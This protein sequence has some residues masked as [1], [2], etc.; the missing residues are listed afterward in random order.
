MDILSFILLIAAFS[1]SYTFTGRYFMHM[2]QLNNYNTPV[3]LKWIEKRAASVLVKAVLVLSTIPLIIFFKST[4]ML[5]SGIIYIVLTYYYKPKDTRQKMVYTK[6]VI[7]MLVTMFILSLIV[8]IL[9]I[10][11]YYSS[12]PLLATIL[13]AEFV[14]SPI[15][16][17]VVKFIN[18][19]MEKQI[20][21]SFVKSAN[22][23][24]TENIKLK[25]IVVGGSFGKTST[26]RYLSELLNI[27]YKVYTVGENARNNI[28]IIKELSTVE[29]DTDIFLCE[30]SSHKIGETAELCK[31]LKPDI[32]I[33]TNIGEQNLDTFKSIEN[34]AQSNKELAQFLENGKLYVNADMRKLVSMCSNFEPVTYGMDESAQYKIFN[35][36]VGEGGTGFDIITPDGETASFVTVLLGEHN[37][38]NL[39]AAIITAHGLGISFED[40]KTVVKNIKSVPHR[41]EL[42]TTANSI[43]IDDSS[44]SNSEGAE[45][46]LNIL[47]SFPDCTKILITPGMSNYA[48][49]QDEYNYRLGESACGICDYVVLIG[50]KQTKYVLAALIENDFDLDKIFVV[51]SLPNAF[52]TLEEIAGS[53]GKKAILLENDIPQSV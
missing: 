7:R 4:G 37:I 14:M 22:E 12:I 42:V 24:I 2:F 53:S 1:L 8:F 15:T 10:V 50:K 36:N 39:T 51:N 41:L 33:I 47:N 34:I 48:S 31:I 19:P 18:I 16:V 26:K 27:R 28:D 3:Y 44:N 20:N 49:K 11:L 30:L 23:N 29:S 35:I 43:L 46:A 52:L 9:A 6:P 21:K 5:I 38:R 45:I 13:A 17:I 32:G 25:T 40:M